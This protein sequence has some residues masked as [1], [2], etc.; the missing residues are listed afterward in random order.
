MGLDNSS[1][2]SKTALLKGHK[3]EQVKQHLVYDAVGRVQ[4]AFTAGIEVA[5][6]EPC[7]VTEYV[8]RNPT[9]TAVVDRQERVYHW[10][11]AW[12][13]NFVFDPSAD[14]DPDGDGV[15]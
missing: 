4:F 11:A 7:L 5:D 13:G 14:Y 6:G 3:L 1:I 15:L 10:K 12:E 9:S 8:Y 2:V